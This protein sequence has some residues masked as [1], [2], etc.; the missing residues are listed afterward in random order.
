M[1]GRGGRGRTLWA[2][3]EEALAA[4]ETEEAMALAAGQSVEH[5]AGRGSQVKQERGIGGGGVVRRACVRRVAAVAC[6]PGRGGRGVEAVVAVS[7][8]VGTNL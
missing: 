6:G 5:P 1:R 2:K 3:A 4:A 8:R 7:L